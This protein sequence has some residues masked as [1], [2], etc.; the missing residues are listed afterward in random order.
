MVLWRI[1]RYIAAGTSDKASPPVNNSSVTRR[2]ALAA[3]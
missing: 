3:R 2:A 1:D